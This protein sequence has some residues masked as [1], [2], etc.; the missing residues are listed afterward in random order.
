MQ[1]GHTALIYAASEGHFECMRI[2]L[3]RGAAKE[4]KD[5]EVRNKIFVIVI[6]WLLP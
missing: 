3:E 1:D 5:S 2:L 4:S 6:V